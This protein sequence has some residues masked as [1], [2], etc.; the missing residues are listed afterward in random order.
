M[1]PLALSIKSL[2]HRKFTVSL[3]VISLA[4]GVALL[5]GV[6][7]MRR[8][9]RSGFTNTIAGTDLIVGARTGQVS[10]L[11]SSVFRIGNPSQNI[12]WET[13]QKIAKNPQV[14]WTI[15][16]SL[17]D[18]HRGYRV[19]GTSEAYFEHYRYAD[20]RPLALEAGE[21]FA[22]T[23]D[24]VLGAEVAR[25][26]GYRLDDAIVLAHGAGEVSFVDHADKPFRVA[27]ILEPTGTP[28]DQ[29]VHV[30][31]AG[32]EAVHE[33]WA[34]HGGG[35]GPEGHNHPAPPDGSS[36]T[37][38]DPHAGHNHPAPPVGTE[39][40][41]GEDSHRGHDHAGEERDEAQAGPEN[42]EDSED[43][44]MLEELEALEKENAA[45]NEAADAHAGHDHAAREAAGGSTDGTLPS[46]GDGVSA[47]DRLA[48]IEAML[49]GGEEHDLQP[50]QITAFL[51][52][53]HSR[54]DAVFLQRAIN[55]YK[56]EALTAVMPGVALQELWQVV[57]VVEK[58]LL[59]VSV[60]VVAVSLA[61]MLSALMTGLNERRRE[62]AILRS[63]GARPFH[64]VSL[65]VGEAVAVTAL[66]C[67]LGVA[68]LYLLLALARPVVLA[69]AGLHLGFS[70]L[71]G[72]E[73]LL[74]AAVMAVGL[75]VGLLPAWRCYRNSLAD[76]LTVKV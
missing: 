8:E 45:G 75:L 23:Y 67:V 46:Q 33:G 15:P 13:Y 27:G 62:M 51:V 30:S 21:V 43:L 24:A 52:G 60:F 41:G 14:A 35:G 69:K 63:V 2:R 10:L 6:E 72:G 47:F 16:I 37:V 5:L 54:A 42:G 18:S 48:A 11:L 61:G 28:V 39:G 74:V 29:T 68:V 38:P 12:S 9:A 73:L 66:A 44:A 64:I 58:T 76:G 20:K 26:L 55:T 31:L 40:G 53:M 57:G 1:S 22:D 36:G 34:G 49:E 56:G 59:V 65:I 7:R 25:E 19:L 32:I 4:L 71:S 50:T 70:M 3:T 17:G